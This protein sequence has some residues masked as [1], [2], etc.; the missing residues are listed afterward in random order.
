MKYLIGIDVGTTGTKS[1]LFDEQG[2]ILASAYK[3]YEVI[4]MKSGY[5]EQKPIAWY[6]AVADTVR[7]CSRRIEK[8]KI[9]AVSISA[10]GGTTVAVDGMGK[11]VRDAIS[12]LDRRAYKEAV[13]LCEKKEKDYYYLNTGWRLNDGYNLAQIKWMKLHEPDNFDRTDKFLSPLSYLNLRLTGNAVTDYTNEAITNLENIHT[14]TWDKTVYEELGLRK[15]Q[16][17]RIRPAGEVIGTLTKESAEIMGLSEKTLVIN[18]GYDQYCAA[19]GLGAVNQ[20]DLMLST[21]TAWVLMAITDCMKFDTKSC[22]SPCQHIMPGKYGVMASLE[23]GGIS[24]DWFKNKVMSDRE[25]AEG[26]ES[27]NRGIEKV[28]PGADGVLFYPH[29]AG[30]TCPYWSK[31][32]KGAFLGLTLYHDRYHM[33]R[34]VMEGVVY[35]MCT[36]LDAYER[37]GIEVKK[38]R[39][40]GGASKSSVWPQ[41]IADIT[42]IPVMI[43]ENADAAARGAGIIAGVGAGMYA[44]FT[45]AVETFQT[46][47]TEIMPDIEKAEIYER[48][49]ARY[50]RGFHELKH[51]YEKEKKNETTVS[52]T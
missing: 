48:N 33:A 12:W 37:A 21:G 39:L 23:T 32:S 7:E 29:F 25:Y 9:Q 51:F 34:A 20:G 22:I 43:F 11:P 13:E 31:S 49:Y 6:Q 44:D 27:L 38:I 19:L 42:Q 41:M 45:E 4:S 46:K 52:K 17:P 5:A 24:L 30:T 40:A 1:L 10:Q 47:S 15:N 2:C 28:N 26:Y 50:Q 14:W 16:L 36:I 35:E 18:G 8:E 3:G